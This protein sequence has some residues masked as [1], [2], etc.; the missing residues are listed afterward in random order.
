MS[1]IQ[2]IPAVAARKQQEVAIALLEDLLIEA[3]SG[4]LVGV[5]AYC[6][7]GKMYKV[8]NTPLASMTEMLGRLQILALE[9]FLLHVDDADS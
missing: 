3:R 9:K 6:D 7:Y 4:V 5:V 1:I 8:K 2:I